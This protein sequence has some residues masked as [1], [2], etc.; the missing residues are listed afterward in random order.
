MT[1]LLPRVARRLPLL[2]LVLALVSTVLLVP[3]SAPAP[4]AGPAQPAL[5]LAAD[6]RL[7]D[8]GN[9]ISDEVFFDWGAMDAGA[10]QAFLDAKGARCVAGAMPCLKDYRQDTVDQPG[11]AYCSTYRGARGETAATLIAKVAAACRINPRVLLVLLQ[12]E[13]GLVTRTQPGTSH[14]TKATG[15]GCPDTAAC[16]PAF[17]GLVSQIYFASR[18]FQRYAAGVAGSYRAG[19]YNTIKWNVPDSCG[20]SQV[21]ILNKATA[22]LYSYTPYRPNQAALDAGYGEGD[23]CSAYGNR[24]FW[25]YFTDWFGST[26]IRT[27]GAIG[28]AYQQQGGG[29]GPL[30]SPVNEMY[31]GLAEGGCGQ[32]FRGGSIFWHPSL[33]A[34]VLNGAIHG[35]WNG[36]G[37]ETGVLGYP[38]S[39]MACG[40][41][42]GGCSQ[43]FQRGQVFWSPATGAHLLNGAIS[44]YYTAAGRERGTLGYPTT[45]IT[46]GLADGGCAQAFQGGW[47]YWAPSTWTHAVGGAIAAAW[48]R[49]GAE[50]G[51]L[52]YPST[53]MT[54]DGTGCTQAFQR[55]DVVWTA[56]TNTTRTVSGAI[57]EAWRAADGAAGPLGLPT[58]D[59]ACG[60]VGNGCR[61]AFR[62][63]WITWAPGAG[64]HA[65][66]GGIG[67][68]WD[69][70]GGESGT[71]GYPTGDMTCTSAGCDQAFQR[72][73]LV[74]TAST[75]TVRSVEGAI[76][77]TW[78]AAGRSTGDLGLPTGAM[79]CTLPGG[80]CAQTFQGGTVVWSSATG[81]R[82]VSGA[83]GWTWSRQGGAA[84]ALGYPSGDMVCLS[85]GCDQAFQKGDLAWTPAGGTRAVSGAIGWL[86]N[87]DGRGA[88]SLGHPTA[89]M[90]CGLTGGGCRQ[91]FAGGLVAWS[92]AGGV[93]ATSGAIQAQWLRSG[94]ESGALGWPVADME[95][96]LENGGCRQSFAGGQVL[97]SPATGTAAVLGPIDASYGANGRQGGVL[98]YPVAAQ[99]CADGGCRQDFQG[100]V[101][102]S[103]TSG[104]AHAVTGGIRAL[105]A[106]LGAQTGALGWP[107]ADMACSATSCGQ[108]FARGEA[109]WSPATGTHAVTG[110]ILDA[111]RAA[112]GATGSLGLPTGDARTSG[113]VTTQTFQ[114][115]TLRHD[116]TTG[117]V[118]RS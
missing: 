102:G 7:F 112:G 113:S 89:D 6:T 9:I 65:V 95:C 35:V 30:G 52:G 29:T 25:L 16:D 26:G 98:G 32:D 85:T 82:T 109:W 15:F 84:G 56:G 13:Q 24:N 76:A 60:L 87:R 91:T 21:Y 36:S 54:C 58:G 68:T 28:W 55:G 8:P 117:Q 47:V 111:W 18:Q 41:T 67:A 48:M 53:E 78:R 37:R 88:G 10:I 74:W 62:G 40:L 14:Y 100:G 46:C 34:H 80:G 75:N 90:V 61:Q 59:M 73:D 66:S 20:T 44:D 11:D 57:G 97:W 115:G 71:L 79:D 116:S 114:G 2:T 23:A 51:P 45:G 99:V 4:T 33:G 27:S 108:R 83:I 103:T 93:H 72:G 1:G 63:G 101:I 12:K 77:Q 86:W 43:Q 5:D 38:T 19:R 22:G 81:A 49:S 64:V 105:W 118:T 3:V 69:R 17:S 107:T 39:G 50:T 94:G 42:G 110:A 31:C 104:G 92:P 106:A 96:Q 70:A